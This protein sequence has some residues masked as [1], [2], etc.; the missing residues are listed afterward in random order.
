MVHHLVFVIH[1]EHMLT[2]YTVYLRAKMGVIYSTADAY[3]ISLFIDL[4]SG[5]VCLHSGSYF[6]NPREF[7]VLNIYFFLFYLTGYS[8]K[9][10]LFITFAI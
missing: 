7:C 2:V 6:L 9:F 1:H 10:V 3:A 5:S 8:R 4:R